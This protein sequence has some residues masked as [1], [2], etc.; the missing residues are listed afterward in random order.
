VASANERVHGF[1][2]VVAFLNLTLGF[3][4]LFARAV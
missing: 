3:G 4:W 1:I 2:A